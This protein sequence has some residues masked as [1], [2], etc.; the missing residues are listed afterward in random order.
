LE[1]KS[2]AAKE[3][4]DAANGEGITLRRSSPARDQGRPFGCDTQPA[5]RIGGHVLNNRSG[6]Q[7][8]SGMDS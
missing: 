8:D 6:A 7:Q 4:L 5:D 1:T 3:D 2:A